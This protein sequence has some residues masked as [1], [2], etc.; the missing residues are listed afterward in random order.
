MLTQSAIELNCFHNYTILNIHFPFQAYNISCFLLLS[1]RTGRGEQ[2]QGAGG[3]SGHRST[4]SP[5]GGG[6]APAGGGAERGG[7]RGAVSPHPESPLESGFGESVPD[8]LQPRAHAD[9]HCRH[10]AG[11][12][13]CFSHGAGLGW[14]GEGGGDGVWGSLLQNFLKNRGALCSDNSI[15]VM[16][17]N[18]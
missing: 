1:W 10:A 7:A 5:G 4:R 18:D 8:A 11:G 14:L 15:L 16:A 13:G 6:A 3:S 9:R 17:V 12:E 2:G